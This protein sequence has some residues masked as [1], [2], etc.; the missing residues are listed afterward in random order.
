[1][2]V[3]IRTKYRTENPETVRAANLKWRSEN[4]ETAI[5]S[6]TGKVKRL[7]V[8]HKHA[9]GFKDMPPE[10]KRLHVRGLLCVVD[11]RLLGGIEDRGLIIFADY[12]QL[13]PLNP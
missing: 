5:D 4:P 9:L 11:N 12:T 6:R 2:L 13:R 7:A 1:M 3:V 8:D 10:Q